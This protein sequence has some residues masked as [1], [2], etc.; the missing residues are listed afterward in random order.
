MH[1]L[2]KNRLIAPL[3]FD[4]GASGNKKL[5]GGGGTPAHQTRLSSSIIDLKESV[6]IVHEFFDHL[7]FDFNMKLV[8]NAVPLQ[9]EGLHTIYQ[10]NLKVNQMSPEQLKIIYYA[11]NPTKKNSWLIFDLGQ[12][13]DVVKQVALSLSCLNTGSASC[14]RDCFLP[15]QL[16][17]QTKQYLSDSISRTVFKRSDFLPSVK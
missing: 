3:N 10:S 17:R 16:S 14:V 15:E 7:V 4:C 13:S 11:R 8:Y 1:Y 5:G 9:Y 2:Q 6:R 12:F